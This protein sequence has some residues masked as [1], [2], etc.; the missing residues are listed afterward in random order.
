MLKKPNNSLSTE[1]G[2]AGSRVLWLD[3]A[4]NTLDLQ[5]F[6]DKQAGLVCWNWYL[7]FLS[8]MKFIYSSYHFCIFLVFYTTLTQWKKQTQSEERLSLWF[9]RKTQQANVHSQESCSDSQWLCWKMSSRLASPWGTSSPGQHS[10]VP[11]T[12]RAV[13]ATVTHSPWLVQILSR[14]G[15]VS[16]FRVSTPCDVC[17]I[18]PT[19]C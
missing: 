9:F 4:V 12:K 6:W 3:D 11:V 15:H 14:G 13:Q 17:L 16:R 1:S 2:L 19:D 7:N 10:N 8:C 5:I 18:N